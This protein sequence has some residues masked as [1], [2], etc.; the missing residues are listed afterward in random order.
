MQFTFDSEDRVERLPDGSVIARVSWYE[1][2][3]D[4]ERDA[5]ILIDHV[6]LP[7][8]DLYQDQGEQEQYLFA[9]IAERAREIQREREF[10][11]QAAKLVPPHLKALARG[12]HRVMPT[13]E[14]VL[15][16][17]VVTEQVVKPEVPSAPGSNPV[18]RA[19]R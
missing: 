6:R 9:T 15:R 3:A 7:Y 12:P 10:K 14:V 2:D 1:D 8:W 4:P 18:P 11:V 5:P 16:Q 17:A 13:G 19:T